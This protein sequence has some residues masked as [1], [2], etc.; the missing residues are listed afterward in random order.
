MEAAKE[1]VKISS[2]K[3]KRYIASRDQGTFELCGQIASEVNSL[4]KE[5]RQRISGQLGNSQFPIG[6]PVDLHF[7][8]T[9]L[10]ERGWHRRE[11]SE[12]VDKV[13]K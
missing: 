5:E 1:K 9:S 7:I 13:F 6:V 11:L 8:L 4:S 2:R 12:L 3:L 10:E